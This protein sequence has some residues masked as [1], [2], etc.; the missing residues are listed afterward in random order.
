MADPDRVAL[1]IIENENMTTGEWIKRSA[2]L[3]WEDICAWTSYIYHWLLAHWPFGPIRTYPPTESANFAVINNE[4]T[5]LNTIA[6]K[7]KEGAWR[8]GLRWLCLVLLGV[9]VAVLYQCIHGSI[10]VID[11]W[12]FDLLHG[13]MASGQ[14]GT[15]WIVQYL[16]MTGLVGAAGL[17]ALYEPMAAGG[18]VA[19]V[20][21]FLN[22]ARPMNLLG[23]LTFLFK[24][25]G[26][27]LTVA[28]GVYVGPEG[29]FIHLGSIAGARIP[30][31]L[32]LAFQHVPVV[33]KALE[34]LLSDTEERNFVV[35]GAAVGIAS[36]FQAPIGGTM[37][38]LEEALSFFDSK[39]IFRTYFTC[40]VSYFTLKLLKE[41]A[42]LSTS[43]LAFSTDAL[44]TT[45]YPGYSAEDL[46]MF[47][48]MGVIGGLLGV[49]YNTVFVRC[50]ML[51]ARFIKRWGWRKLAEIAVVCMVTSLFI[52]F[53]PIGYGCSPVTQL[54][55]Q[56]PG[57][58]PADE[59]TF[60]NPAT[61]NEPD[62]CIQD[63]TRN[64]FLNYTHDE[65]SAASLLEDKYLEGSLCPEGHY[66]ELSSL[67]QRNG[68]EAATLL[69][70]SGAY[71]MF[72]ARAIAIFGVVYFFLCAIT[73]GVAVPAGIFVPSMTIGA[74]LGRLL[75]IFTN[76][77]VKVPLGNAPV[78]PGPWAMIGAAAF[79]CGSARIT[80]TMAIIILEITGDFRYV[81]GIAIAVVFAKMTGG[82]FTKSIYHMMIHLKDIPFLEDIPSSAMDNVFVRDIMATPVVT[83][84]NHE[85]MTNL[86]RILAGCKHNGFPIVREENG[87]IR[88]C[89]VILREFLARIVERAPSDSVDVDVTAY[90]NETPFTVQPEFT[91]TQAFRMFRTLGLR[92]LPVVNK[93]FE[94]QG[95]ITRRDFL[96][97]H[98]HSGAKQTTFEMKTMR[99]FMP[100]LVPDDV[101][102]RAAG[103]EEVADSAS[104][105]A[106]SPDGDTPA[107]SMAMVA[108]PMAVIGDFGETVV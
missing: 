44:K 15:G 53:V 108:A 70:A 73:A 40:A 88:L 98:R 32:Y 28:A 72:H 81:P 77:W 11:E 65:S 6:R 21:S 25:I 3:L 56:L 84:R 76:V 82:F 9:T 35:A 45:C 33:G 90:M 100:S 75:A 8:V 49:L 52:V 104:S 43:S 79:L 36:A 17:M 69:F 16:I 29:P 87:H 80:V 78:D 26:V 2:S 102:L 93:D 57:F 19:E 96:E 23:Y 103:E 14:Y 105:G 60:M 71:D 46:I 7:K 99:M 55:T 42:W 66:N 63:S 10:E 61:Y 64:F 34:S 67:F 106:D 1:L 91:M 41:G 27:T 97:S 30:S 58:D 5:R 101:E 74:C 47:G 89:G 37:F 18:G 107:P 95:I 94:L 13:Y 59:S 24:A 51:R 54:A 39:L 68:H 86:R 48:L 92:H 83:L 31:L 12:K 85:S 62:I 38:V 4:R 20:I 50:Q 22:G